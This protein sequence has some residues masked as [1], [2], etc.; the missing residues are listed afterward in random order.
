MKNCHMSFS[1]A[2]GSF[3]G[4]ASGLVFSD[5]HRRYVLDPLDMPHR[6]PALPLKSR[7][8][9]GTHLLQNL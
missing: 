5:R 2:Y 8:S 9:Y 6:S 1:G 7:A 4:N 3:G